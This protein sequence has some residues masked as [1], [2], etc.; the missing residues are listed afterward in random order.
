MSGTVVFYG[1][2]DDLIEVEGDVTGC[3]EYTADHNECLSFVVVGDANCSTRVALSYEKDGIWAAMLGQV[4][5]DTPML[6]AAVTSENYTARV[7]FEGVRIVIPTL[8]K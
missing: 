7:T 5:E 8:P 6:P 3:D 4:N 2:S 1:A